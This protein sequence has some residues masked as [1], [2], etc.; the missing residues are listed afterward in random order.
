MP[1]TT[2]TGHQAEQQRQRDPQAARRRVRRGVRMPVRLVVVVIVVAH[3]MNDGTR[4]W[5]MFTAWPH[6]VHTPRGS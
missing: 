5:G 2:S 4:G 3:A 6:L 1:K